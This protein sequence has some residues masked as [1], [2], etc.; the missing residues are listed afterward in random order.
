MPGST[1]PILAVLRIGAEIQLW[2]CS[3]GSL[4]TYRFG[5][6]SFSS[7]PSQTKR[8]RRRLSADDVSCNP[9]SSITVRRDALQR[10]DLLPISIPSLFGGLAG[11]IN[12]PDYERLSISS[13]SLKTRL[14]VR[15]RK[16][17]GAGP[18]QLS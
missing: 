10:I 11:R 9:K 12:I 4:I 18:A 16:N 1:E 6:A 2:T 7:N 14:V 13:L 15:K 5:S 17:C 3:T 8:R